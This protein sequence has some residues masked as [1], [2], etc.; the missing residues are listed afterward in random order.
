MPFDDMMSLVNDEELYSALWGH[1]A[2]W[3]TTPRPALARARSNASTSS[4]VTR[5]G[6]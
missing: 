4:N 6:P 1:A 2:V 5:A 3:G